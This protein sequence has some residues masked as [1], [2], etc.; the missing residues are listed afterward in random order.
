VGVSDRRLLSVLERLLEL[1]AM[2]VEGILTSCADLIADAIPCEKVDA[3]IYDTAT[4]TL[5]AVGTSQTELA[6]Q[7]RALGLDR[8]P[9]ANDDPVARVFVTGEPYHNGRTHQDPQQPRGV[10]EELG[11]RS[12]LAVPLEVEKVRRGILA[13][14]S[15]TVDAF[16]TDDLSFLSIIARWIGGLVHRSELQ[17]ASASHAAEAGRRLAAEELITMVAH[18]LRNLL[19]P[20]SGRAAIVLDRAL[21]DGRTEDIEAC[22]RLLAGLARVASLMSDLLDVARIKQ[23]MLALRYEPID[24][25]ALL[26]SIAQ[27]MALPSIPVRLE[28]ELSRLPIVADRQRLTQ[29]FENIVSNA[30]KH[31]PH[32]AAVRIQVRVPA[33]NHVQVTIVDQGSGISPEI[34]SHIFERYVARGPAAGLGLG[35]YFARAMVSAHGGSIRLESDG[36]RGTR[37]EI[38]LPLKPMPDFSSRGDPTAT[39]DAAA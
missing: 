36:S 32:D 23:D 35:L 13:L 39:G 1:G 3:F 9:I 37:C 29:A 22:K 21:A 15:K 2:P 7:Q 34:M 11:V 27:S 28:T 25:I 16:S 19:T 30:T 8:L 24:L 5:I 6:R 33:E 4:S 14:A 12:M 38:S 31:S 17:Q 26:S 10:I 20:I 18:D